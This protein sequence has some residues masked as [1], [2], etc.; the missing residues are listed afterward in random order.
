MAAGRGRWRR[1]VPSSRLPA[2][3]ACGVPS[4]TSADAD[5]AEKTS[6]VPL[7]GRPKVA[8]GK[9]ISG[10]RPEKSCKR[11]RVARNGEC[12]ARP[13]IICRTVS[14]RA[15][16]LAQVSWFQRCKGVQALLSECKRGLVRTSDGT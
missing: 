1:A 15:H 7:G 10:F 16:M 6:G 5:G 13:P 14:T 9:W 2:L 11:D 3:L 8:Y 12:M 4:P